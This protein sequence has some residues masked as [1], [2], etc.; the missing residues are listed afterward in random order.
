MRRKNFIY[1]I[2]TSVN[3]FLYIHPLSKPGN[4]DKI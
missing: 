4:A 2:D 3:E 1:I